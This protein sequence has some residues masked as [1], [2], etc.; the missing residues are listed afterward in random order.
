M[1]NRAYQ[2]SLQFTKGLQ[3]H[4]PTWM[5]MMEKRKRGRNIYEVLKTRTLEIQV[6]Q[7]QHTTK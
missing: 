1:K 2:K 7:M 3:E 5:E 6:D 4:S